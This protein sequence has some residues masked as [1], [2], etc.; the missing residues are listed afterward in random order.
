M[1]TRLFH[2]KL[3][4]TNASLVNHEAFR[5]IIIP[6]RNAATY[7][8]TDISQ[9]HHLPPLRYQPQCRLNHPILFMPRKTEMHE[10][11]AVKRLRHLLQ[12]G[13]AARVV[14]DQIIVGREDGGDFTL[15]GKR[16]NRYL[17]VLE[18]RFNQDRC[19]STYGP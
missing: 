8:A 7:E 6:W 12:N 3:A 5:R 17:N 14:L 2:A 13:D 15:D 4:I 9:L 16:R 11:L 1:S 19:S 18:S 10:P